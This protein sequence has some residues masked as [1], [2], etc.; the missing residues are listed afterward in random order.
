MEINSLNVL[1][2]SEPT[3]TMM[4]DNLESNNIFPELHILNNLKK[5]DLLPY[6][7]PLF[8]IHIKS[9]IDELDSSNPYFLGVNKPNNKI[10]VYAEMKIATDLFTSIIHK[11]TAISS[12]TKI[13]KGVHIN[14]LVSIAAFSTIKDFVSINRNCSIGHHSSIGKFTT[15]NPGANIAGFVKIG[16]GC[17][18]G[19]GVNI[20]DG[21]EIGSN[22][23]IGAG[24]VVTKNIPDNVVAY[25]NPCKII[26]SNET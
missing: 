9:Q 3:I 8:K 21:F 26:R 11:H 22:T 20:I 15:V 13:G 7:N 16:S 5:V 1:G 25:G 14:S 10:T 24:S 19:M 17:L 4:Q 12:T 18:I 6:E 2:I 23:I